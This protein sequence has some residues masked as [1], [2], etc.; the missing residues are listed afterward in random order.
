MLGFRAS[1]FGISSSDAGLAAG[2]GPGRARAVAAGG[3]RRA[4]PGCAPGS[5]ADK[6][7]G[8]PHLLRPAVYGLRATARWGPR[9]AGEGETR[10]RDSRQHRQPPVVSPR[11]PETVRPMPCGM[12]AANTR[13]L[14][15]KPSGRACRPP[16]PAMR[17]SSKRCGRTGGR[18]LF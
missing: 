2:R 14:E 18:C 10:T 12:R 9:G 1:A 17:P 7:T 4:A 8:C 15:R 16:A 13:H 5:Q 6:K 3:G 11:L